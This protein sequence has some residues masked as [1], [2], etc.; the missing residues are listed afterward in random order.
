MYTYG[1]ILVADSTKQAYELASKYAKRYG[2]HNVS[3]C[4]NYLEEKKLFEDTINDL[5]SMYEGLKEA[6]ENMIKRFEG[7]VPEDD[8]ILNTLK[9][10]IKRYESGNYAYPEE[11]K[12]VYHDGNDF[13]HIDNYK[14]FENIK[15]NNRIESLYL[16]II[17]L[18]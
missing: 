12:L 2:E 10:N 8:Y 5:I 4:I 9:E 7:K 11:W 17:D 14:I 3:S 16:L 15:D 13:E 1:L 18:P 6:S